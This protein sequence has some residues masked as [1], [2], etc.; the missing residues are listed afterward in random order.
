MSQ[1]TSGLALAVGEIVMGPLL[2]PLGHSRYQLI[3]SA[4]GLTAFM[5]AMA[6]TGAS[7]RG[8]AIAVSAPPLSH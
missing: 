4:I 7:T 6:A 2:K 8:M 1:C 5:G 3:F